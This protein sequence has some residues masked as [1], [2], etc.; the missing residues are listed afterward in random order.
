MKIH[1]CTKNPC[2]HQELEIAKVFENG[3]TTKT[4]F[5]TSR[6]CGVETFTISDEPR[7]RFEYVCKKCLKYCDIKQTKTTQDSGRG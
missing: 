6:C 1:L 2:P 5:P 3:F 4:P 7:Q